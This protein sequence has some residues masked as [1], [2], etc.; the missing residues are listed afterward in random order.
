[1]WGYQVYFQTSVE[2]YLRIALREVGFTGKADVIL[3]G[4]QAQGEHRYPI[5]FEPEDG[6]YEPSVLA[7]V[8]SRGQ[9]LYEQH[10]D[11]NMFYTDPQTD[12]EFHERL[13]RQMRSRAV[14][15]ALASSE[16]GAGRTVFARHAYTR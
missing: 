8:A 10:S 14:E 11:R 1:M 6:P 15:E 9:E 12:E 7:N 2:T 16:P 5:C 3:V 13:Q 4:F